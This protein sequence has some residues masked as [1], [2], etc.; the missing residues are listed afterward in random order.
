M[1]FGRFLLLATVAGCLS[2]DPGSKANAAEYGFSTY[3]VGQ[4]SFGAGV[5]PP[6]GTYVTEAVGVY[7]ANIG[8]SITFGD[9]AVTIGAGAHVRFETAAINGLY[10]FDHKV[11]GGNLGISATVPVGFMSLDATVGPISRSI[12]GGGLGDIV[13]KIQLGWQHGEFSQTI[14]VQAVAPT[15]RYE[16]GFNPIIGL[17]RPGIDTGWAFTWANKATNLQL[18]GALGVTFNFENTATTCLSA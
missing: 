4:N 18:N 6:P 8:R 5:T 3:G 1:D 15:G 12:A 14:Y 10:V 13:S 7:T 17:H 9:P 16:T 11:L 2:L